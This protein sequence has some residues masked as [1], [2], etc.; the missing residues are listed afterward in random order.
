MAKT[1]R[2]V[3][4][5]SELK[6]ALADCARANTSTFVWGP[7]GIG[8]SQIAKQV[9]SELG[10][11]TFEDIRLSQR[12]PTD[13]RGIPMP[14]S[15]EFGE[16]VLWSR[17]DFID[18]RTRA[19][20][21][22]SNGKQRK[23]MYLFDEMNSA[24]MSVQAAAYQIV[25]DRKIGTHAL[26]PND[27]VM[28]AG[29][30]ETDKGATYRM[31]S[32]LM[33]RFIHLE[34]AP[35]FEDWQNHAIGAHYNPYVVGFLTFRKKD[36]FDFDP[37]NSSRGFATPRSWEMVSKLLNSKPTSGKDV[38]RQTIGGAVGE[39][40]SY[41]F[42]EYRERSEKLPDPTKILTGEVSEVKDLDIGL[43]YSLMT[44]LSYELVQKNNA[45]KEKGGEG[46]DEWKQYWEWYN[47]MIVFVVNNEKYTSPEMAIMALRMIINIHKLIPDPKR[48]PAWKDWSSRFA[49]L[50]RDA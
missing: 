1:E 34:L 50:V 3:L 47:N 21:L 23:A 49:K 2:A 27:F 44:A 36:L 31:A 26:G 7:P 48:L 22:N 4:K 6:V 5:P 43:S 15:D 10:F 18:P 11:D 46:S 16:T 32:P 20:D 19:G 37:K 13:L 9:S 42:M 29:N 45:W 24:P 30:R 40:I 8:K 25:L 41:A 12:E 17:P 35:D 38:L 14:T 28:A 39:G 33:N